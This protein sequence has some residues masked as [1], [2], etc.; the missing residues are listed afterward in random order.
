MPNAPNFIQWC[1]EP[2]LCCFIQPLLLPYSNLLAQHSSY[3]SFP[4]SLYP[5]PGT[6]QRSNWGKFSIPH[7]SIVWDNHL[8]WLNK[9]VFSE[10]PLSQSIKTLALAS[11]ASPPGSGPEVSSAFQIR[12]KHFRTLQESLL[13]YAHSMFHMHINKVVNHNTSL[14]YFRQY[15]LFGWL[16]DWVYIL[17]FP[18]QHK[19]QGDLQSFSTTHP[20]VFTTLWGGCYWV[21]LAQ[22]DQLSFIAGDGFKPE[23]SRFQSNSLSM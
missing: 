15:L 11:L 19:A 4:L 22:D 20:A 21:L 16:V 2:R 14:G 3:L 12:D 18:F 5:L 23:S 8:S 7:W 13:Y 17:P 10:L 1:G 6:G 9:E